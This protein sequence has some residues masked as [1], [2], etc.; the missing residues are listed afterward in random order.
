MAAGHFSPTLLLINRPF[1]SLLLS[2]AKL[3]FFLEWTL[4]AIHPAQD[5]TPSLLGHF[6]LSLLLL[7]LSVDTNVG[8]DFT[9]IQ[10]GL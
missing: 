1:L 2:W 8:T 9:S 5:Q 4:C 6:L 3:T 10:L 7:V